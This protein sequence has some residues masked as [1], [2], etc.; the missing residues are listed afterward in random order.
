[1]ILHTLT[2]SRMTYQMFLLLKRTNYALCRVYF[3]CFSLFKIIVQLNFEHHKHVSLQSKKM[4]VMQRRQI[5]TETSLH[6]MY[7][8]ECLHVMYS[9]ESHVIIM[10]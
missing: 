5:N 10:G 8:S 1:M 3:G 2:D 4:L 9:F 6:V 7:S